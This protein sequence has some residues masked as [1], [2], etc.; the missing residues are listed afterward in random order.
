MITAEM[1]AKLSEEVAAVA[2]ELKNI[3][4]PNRAKDICDKLGLQTGADF[5]AVQ[6]MLNAKIKIKLGRK[7]GK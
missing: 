6:S 3:A 5:N 1:Q 4:I 2:M 7:G